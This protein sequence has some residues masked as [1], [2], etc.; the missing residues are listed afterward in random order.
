MKFLCDQCKAKYQIA[1]DKVAGR[2]VRMKCR[3]C[4]H[5]I[6][7]RA[8]VTESSVARQ[9]PRADEPRSTGGLATSLSAARPTRSS[10]APGALAGAFHK[11]FQNDDEDEKTMMAM[12]PTAASFEA[13]VTEEWY[14][15]ING[16]PVGPMRLAELRTKAA[17]GAITEDTLVWQEGF[18]EWRPVKTT[19]QLLGIVR[20]AVPS[21]A[22]TGQANQ[23][24]NQSSAPPVVAPRVAV[25]RPSPAR[26]TAPLGPAPAALRSNVVPISRGGAGGA[27][28][29]AAAAALAPVTHPVAHPSPAAHAQPAAALSVVA[30]PVT[31]PFA[32]VDPFAAPA[33]D[34][35]AFP[36]SEPAAAVSA[37]MF[38]P[39]PAPVAELAPR[40]ALV[41]IPPPPPARSMAPLMFV[42]AVVLAGAF[43]I[44]AA[45]MTFK[46]GPAP[47]AVNTAT[48]APTPSVALPVASATVENPVAAPTPSAS[49]PQKIAALGPKPAGTGGATAAPPKPGGAADLSGMGLNGPTPTPTTG[50]GGSS[51]GPA[52]AAG[53]PL[54]T[55]S[56]GKT[57]N[58][59]KAAV[60]RKCWDNAGESAPSANVSVA[61]TV[62]SNGSVTAA[63]G[64]GTPPAVAKC[65]ENHVRGWHFD[66]TG[67]VVIPFHFV[68]Q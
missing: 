4:G 30:A 37:P 63:S 60:K 17:A 25:T 23:Q 29:A 39:A 26:V 41:S 35:F 27:G 15:A 65:V 21:K 52:A 67:Q 20:E 57:I 40:S 53:Q 7:V 32:G 43:G 47:V 42:A 48:A 54:D 34:P 38:T 18:E 55:A 66:G 24:A 2:T 22:L 56:V 46:S 10:V 5:L 61:I 58:T 12:A 49:A 9:A 28:G 3:K 6:E 36:P 13:S 44:T 68:R 16:L 14:A 8:E 59:Y 31:N 19:T 45:V 11:R 62:G 1:D 33:A 64:S 51:P 50:G